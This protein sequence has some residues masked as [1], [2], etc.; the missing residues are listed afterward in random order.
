ME[1]DII[2]HIGNTKVSTN[3]QVQKAVQNA[4]SEITVRIRRQGKPMQVN[5]TPVRCIDGSC[6]ML[7]IWIRDS[8]AGIGTLTFY[9]PE[10]K[11][12]GALG[13]GISDVDT[14]ELMPL[15]SGSI[16][17]STVKSIQK[18]VAGTPGEL[19]GDFNL[20][21]DAG[22]LYSN[23]DCGI[24]GKLNDL[25]LVKEAKAVPVASKNEI[26]KG[27]ISILSNVSGDTVESYD[28]EIIKIYSDEGQPS[29][30]MMI[31]I[32]DER[33]IAL[34]G[35]IVQGMSGSP[36]LQ[37]G[38]LI[39]AVTHVLVNDPKRGYGI[40]IENMLEEAYAE[41]SSAA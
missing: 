5:I 7:G 12:F 35:G 6:Y 8:M 29:R 20:I 36:I 18:G 17:Y 31:K 15:S 22:V 38:K 19:K 23:S 10:T 9:D 4:D 34:T 1:G 30:N 37:D 28:A 2:T 21:K 41:G 14:L 33:L 16:M 40:F 26:V 39:G 13:H 11:V 32:T 27:K 3:E 25:S 24:F